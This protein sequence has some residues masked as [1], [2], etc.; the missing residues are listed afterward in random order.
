MLIRSIF[1]VLACGFALPAP[2]ARIVYLAEQD[3]AYILELYLVDLERPGESLK[4]NRPLT[5]FSEG[6]GS[7]AISPNGS[8]IAFSADQD[9]SGDPDLHLVDISAPGT[10]TRVGDLPAGAREGFPKFSADGTRLA[11]TASDANIGSTA[12]YLVELANPG[13]ATRMN[14][15]LAPGGAVSLTGFAFT[16]DGSHLVYTAGEL[17][18]RFELYAVAV[19]R[20][21]E[22]ARLN[23]PG[24]TVGDT[25]EGRFRVL[26]DNRSVVY[27]AVWQHAGQREVH[28]VSLDAPGQPTTLNAPFAGSGYTW[29]FDVSPDGQQVVYI[30]ATD[31]SGVPAAWLVATDTPGV[32]RRISGEVQN[33]AWQARFT[34]DGRYAVFAADGT[35]A[36]GAHDLFMAPVSGGPDAMRLSAP[37]AGSFSAG[38]YALSSDGLQV[39]YSVFGGTGFAEELWVGRLDSPGSGIRV[40]E[41]LTVEEYLP[42]QFSPDGTHVA[43]AAVEDVDVS[44]QQLYVASVSAPGTPIRINDTLPPGGVIATSPHAFEFLPSGAPPTGDPPPGPSPTTGEE[45]ASS[46]G[47]SFGAITLLLLLSALRP[48]HRRRD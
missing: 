5:L 48:R 16:P 23:A 17:E 1:A 38:R 40:S 7:F 27:S 10:W 35:R 36:A 31:T 33:G 44:I 20:P 46:G 11:F 12:L 6:V 13:Y 42:P 47:G 37:L 29:E 25:Y 4:L 3:Y 26:A 9:V 45:A 39:A 14:G 41:S 18:R 21:G 19:D 15:E 34:N 43:F 28:M 22:S 30:A 24:G 32:A 2:A 8:Q